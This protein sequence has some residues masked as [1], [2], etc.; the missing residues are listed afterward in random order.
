MQEDHWLPCVFPIGFVGR[1]YIFPKVILG[2]R[3][4]ED[5]FILTL[6][7]VVIQHFV[8]KGDNHIIHFCLSFGCISVK[9]PKVS[10]PV[11]WYFVIDSSL[12]DYHVSINENM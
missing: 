10:P 5:E 8:Y 2:I 12:K 7:L 11:D 9:S 3:K 4:A 6:I 1:Q